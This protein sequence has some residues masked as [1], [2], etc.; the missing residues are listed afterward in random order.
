MAASAQ[1]PQ[2]RKIHLFAALCSLHSQL[3]DECQNLLFGF[4]ERGACIDNL[5]SQFALFRVG[6]LQTEYVFELVRRHTGAGEDPLPLNLGRSR[7]NHNR[8]DGFV[9]AAFEQQWN[10]K[11]DERGI[12]II[13]EELRPFLSDSRVDNRLKP[14]EL[15]LVSEYLATQGLAID[16][17]RAGRSWE[18]GFDLL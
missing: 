10:I 2:M 11:Q 13:R 16:P 12:G 5:I 3:R 7:D 18:S 9:T 15:F 8:V 1:E 14:R 4:S 17:I 6:D